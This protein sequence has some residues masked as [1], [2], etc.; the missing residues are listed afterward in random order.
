M[1]QYEPQAPAPNT[2]LAIY[3]APSS[4]QKL[5]DTSPFRLK[6]ELK[7][8][9]WTYTGSEILNRAEAVDS[10]NQTASESKSEYLLEGDDDNDEEGSS[11]DK[12]NEAAKSIKTDDNGFP[13][14]GGSRTWGSWHGQ[15]AKS[16][17]N[18]VLQPKGYLADPTTLPSPDTSEDPQP[19]QSAAPLAREFMLYVTPS[20]MNHR[21]YIERQGY[22]TDFVPN[23]KTIMA[24]DLE[25][26]VPLQGLFDCHVKK[27]EVSLRSRNKRKDRDLHGPFSLSA[28]WSNRRS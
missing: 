10:D 23:R 25:S 26:R 22:Y 20:R 19:L 21:A 7:D 12:A 18:Q 16:S 24:G 17:S 8:T 4:A 9:E 1:I 2:I 11:S 3:Q 27:D 28:L 5:L 15:M 14:F 13:G 6:L